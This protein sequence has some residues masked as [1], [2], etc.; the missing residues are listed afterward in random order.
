MR[1]AGDDC[2]SDGEDGEEGQSLS[3]S[4]LRHHDCLSVRC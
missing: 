1:I 4:E 2:A 3:Q